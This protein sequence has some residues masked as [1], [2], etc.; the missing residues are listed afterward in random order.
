MKALVDVK[1]HVK[2]RRPLNDKEYLME[3]VIQAAACLPDDFVRKR[4]TEN[5]VTTLWNDELHAPPSRVLLGDDFNFR[6]P[7]G[8]RNNCLFPHIGAAGMPYA[9]TVTPTTVGL[10]VLP[11]PGVLF[12]TLMKREAPEEHPS[13]ISSM[14]FY[15]ASIII[16]DCFK[17]NGH[18][19]NISDT[20]SYLDLEPLYGGDWKHQ[21]LMRTFKDGKIKPDCFSESRL[22]QFPPGAGALLIMFNRYHNYVVDQLATIKEG[23][24]FTE[25]GA[26]VDRYGESSLDKR[27]DDLFQTGR[28]ITCGLYV[29][30]ILSDYVRTILNLNRT[31]SDWQLDPRIDI[32]GVPRGTGNQVSCEFNLVYRWHASV[33]ARDEAWTKKLFQQ[34]FET[35]PG[36]VDLTSEDDLKALSK[37]AEIKKTIPEEPQERSWPALESEV[38]KRDESGKYNDHE[39]AAILTSSIE[40][41]ANATGPRRIPAIMK[42]ISTLGITQARTWGLATLNEFRSHF[43]L[44]PHRTFQSITRDKEAAKAL[45][46]LYRHP[47]NVELYPGLV[48]EDAK[49]PMVPGSGLCPGYTISRAVLSDAVGLVRGDRFYTTSYSPNTLT[50]WGYKDVATDPA[51]DNGCV[52]YK[53]FKRALPQSYDDRSVYVHYP[54]TVPHGPNGMKEVLEKLGKAKMYN[55]DIPASSVRSEKGS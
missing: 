6:Q 11:D 13:K 5:F 29:N 30:I 18:D 34:V 9:R 41:C 54:L 7:D 39:L 16:H 17:T 24:R 25:T 19:Y 40:D 45:E 43:G 31:D 4:I 3:Y 15:L 8:S 50:S 47:D 28:L 46:R 21:K 53:L 33:S 23:G 48:V 2:R 38:L 37:L 49:R 22:L 44:E 1:M 36:P 26:K 35:G 52:F 55:F 10:D 14:L 51:I 42:F 27:D 32:P 12:D 20:S